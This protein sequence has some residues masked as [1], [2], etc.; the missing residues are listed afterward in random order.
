MSKRILPALLL[1]AITLVVAPIAAAEEH[2]RVG[3]RI[4]LFAGNVQFFPAGQP[5]HISHGW[6]LSPH[7]GA[8]ALA[9][10]KYGFS[11]A[12]D[13]Q[14]WEDDYVEKTKVEHP[15]FGT[16]QSRATVF[17]FPDGMTGTHTFTGHWFGPCAG[18]VA[19]G[20]APG[21]CEH[22]TETTTSGGLLTITVVFVP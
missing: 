7:D 22:P 12:V 14:E 6:G 17:K 19:G 13:G 21:P 1:L 2:E 4:N 18:L 15:D 8:P 9:L 16:L 10:G 20:F 5:F 11:L 3:T